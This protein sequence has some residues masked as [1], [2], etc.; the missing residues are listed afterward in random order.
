MDKT[1]KTVCNKCNGEKIIRAFMHI[2]NGRCFTC[3]GAGW[4]EL[5][6]K[7]SSAFADPNHLS[8]TWWITEGRNI[9]NAVQGWANEGERQP[10]EFIAEHL[11]RM[12]KAPADVY[13]RF[14][15]ALAKI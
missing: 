10:D 1:T 2:D 3:M 6:T 5:S 14:T 7:K 9:L 13:A 4:V 11:E 8:R 12:S 15:T